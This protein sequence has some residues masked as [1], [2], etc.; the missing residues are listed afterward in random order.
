MSL[1]PSNASPLE[2]GLAD[3]TRRI[4]DIPAYPNH[5]WNPDTC[6]A[7]CLPWLAWALSVDVWNPDWPE[8]VKRQTIANSVAVHRIKGTRGALKKA[9]DALNVQ[10]E[11]KEWFEY[12]GEPFTFQVTAYA[13]DNL[14]TSGD[15]LNKALIEQ[16]QETIQR[17]KNVRSHFS[18][19]LGAKFNT[20][21]TAGCVTRNI[22]S[23]R[24]TSVGRIE[25][26]NTLGICATAV[27][28]P[29]TIIR[30]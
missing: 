12:H 7:N 29:L 24:V 28:R 1:L 9:L 6:P 14:N 21:I 20:G 23:I 27:V 30:V 11:I 8:Y 18:F 22:N 10:T 26:R 13:N 25:Q 19:Q 5:V 4:S 15:I 2:E 3:S 17:T 16:I